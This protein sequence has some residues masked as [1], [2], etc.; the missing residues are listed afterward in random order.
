M[1]SLINAKIGVCLQCWDVIAC[2][3]IL[4]FK[5]TNMQE[6]RERASDM[7]QLLKKAKELSSKKCYDVEEIRSQSK[8][9]KR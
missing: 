1:K 2:G 8:T 9:T 6:S 4:L 3:M 5:G 7:L